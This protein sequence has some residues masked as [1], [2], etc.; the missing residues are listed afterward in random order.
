MPA[1]DFATSTVPW[2][3]AV[4][5]SRRE[6][7]AYLDAAADPAIQALPTRCP[8]WSVADL[9]AHLAATFRRFADQLEKARA[10]DLA[11]PFPRSELTD[12]NLRAVRDFD[13][14]P[15]SELA[16]HADRFLGS[17][18]AV[19]E[20]IGHQLGPIPVGLQV[21]FG[22][23]ELTVHH[24]D[25]AEATGG[26]YRPGGDTVA[27]MVDVYGVVSGVPAGPDPWSCL[28][29]ATGR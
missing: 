23:V 7:R 22:L 17:V 3:D 8:A 1:G 26:S 11:A 14:D 28:L 18:D 19:D 12:E 9:S 27:A 29:Q 24:D 2:P 15:L 20:P 10:G 21:M 16:L 6:L 25:L 13:G 5:W 4:E